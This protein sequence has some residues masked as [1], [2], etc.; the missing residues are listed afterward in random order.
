MKNPI[1]RL[2]AGV[3]A[4]LLILALGSLVRNDFETQRKL[5]ELDRQEC[6][7]EERFR[8][9]GGGRS[10]SPRSVD[11]AGYLTASWKN[12]TYVGVAIGAFAAF[13]NLGLAL[14]RPVSST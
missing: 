1:V 12:S 4:L 11:F 2:N 5:T 6:F 10:G 9:Y 7:N 14:R 8:A 13:V 3:L